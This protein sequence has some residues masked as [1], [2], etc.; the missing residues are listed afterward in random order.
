MSGQ[1]QA[2]QLFHPV[3]INQKLFILPWGNPDLESAIGKIE[4][5]PGAV[6][7]DAR[8]LN[9]AERAA[10]ASALKDPRTIAI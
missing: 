4:S 9:V 5:R 7:G 1:T 10:L 6:I 8:F 2:P 3:L